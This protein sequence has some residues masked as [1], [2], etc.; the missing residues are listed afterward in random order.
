MHVLT[1]LGAIIL[2]AVTVYLFIKLLVH[3][4]KNKRPKRQRGGSGN[5]AQ[6]RSERRLNKR[7]R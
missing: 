7:R 3:F 6:R 4:D 2:F 5:R 1:R